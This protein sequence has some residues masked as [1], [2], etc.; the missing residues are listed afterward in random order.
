MIRFYITSSMKRWIVPVMFFLG[1]CLSGVTPLS[2]FAAELTVKAYVDKTELGLNQ[3]FTLHVELSGKDVNRASNPALPNMEAFAAFLGSGSSQNIQY[4]NGKM[5]ASKTISYH[6]QTIAAG[7]FEIG[8]ITVK[9]GNKEYKTN[10][11]RI[12]VQKTSSSRPSKQRNAAR[13]GTGPAESDLFL[14]A[15]VNK[16]RVYQNEPVIVTYKIYTRL[17]VTSVGFAKIPT[18]AGFWAEDFMQ[19]QQQPTT[20]TVIL[21]GKQYTMAAVRKMGLFPMSAG[22]KTIEP[23]V[24]N[25]DVRVSRQ[26]RDRFDSFFNDPFFGRTVKK[27]IQSKP[28]KIEVLALPEEGKPKDFS[29]VVG[30]FS[31]SGSLDKSRIKANEAITYKVKIAGAG[32]IRTLPVPKLVFPSDFEVYP[33]KSSENIQRTGFKVTG[34]KTYEYVLVP[35]NPGIYHIKPVRL[36]YFDPLSR[37]YKTVSTKDFTVDVGK[38]DDTFVV[39]HSGLSKEEVKL[40]GQDIR[41]IKTEM[42]AFRKGGGKSGRSLFLLFVLFAPLLCLVSAVFYRRHLNRLMGDEAYARQR[43]ATRSARKHFSSARSM[44]KL[45]SQK[46]FYAGV[47]KALMGFVGNKLNVS[48]A[49]MIAEDVRRQ[50]LKRGAKETSVNDYFGCLEICDLKRFSPAESSEDEMKALLQRAENVL[51]RLDKEISK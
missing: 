4:V 18:T 31:M 25:C 36:S 14:R 35:R 24:V 51:S 48:E 33:P 22:Q 8:P 3:Q 15:E 42:T 47:G 27:T 26:S 29:G 1:F 10:P 9:A 46:A 49:G 5:S 6:F 39:T 40:L 19:G 13:Q 16:K 11:I 34:S 32:N 37:T 38:G 45:S 20:S 44:L 41:F 30:Q 43:I 2:A 17:S 7:T 12:Q 50:L 21:E 23:L 28:I